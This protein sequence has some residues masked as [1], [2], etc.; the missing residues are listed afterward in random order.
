MKA[1]I[2]FVDDEPNVLRSF[3][4]TLGGKLDVSF[5][6]GGLKAV[7]HLKAH[8]DVGVVVTDM[9][10][11]GM[12]GLRFIAEA[13]KIVPQAVFVML[14]GN[15]DLE[16]ARRAVNEG[17]VFRFLNKPVE[18]DCLQQ[19]LAASLEHFR[20]R[21]AEREL[22]GKTLKGSIHLLTDMLG[23]AMPEVASRNSRVAELARRVAEMLNLP[24]V[25]QIEV[26]A[27]L[28]QIG[29]FALPPH[30][31]EADDPKS[32]TDPLERRQWQSHPQRALQMLE[33][34]PRLDLPGRIIAAQFE[35]VETPELTDP[36]DPK[37]LEGWSACIVRLALRFTALLAEGQSFTAAQ[38]QLASEFESVCP[39]VAQRFA[40]L[41]SEDVLAEAKKMQLDPQQLRAGMH[42]AG[43]LR[44]KTGALLLPT[45]T[46]INAALITKIRA[47]A[48]CEMLPGMIDVLV[49]ASVVAAMAGDRQA[50]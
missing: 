40:S 49:P 3:R 15:S 4:R 14:T 34:I 9:R 37:Q 30:L 46:P 32:I 13:R 18:S 19:C 7:E 35:A 23:L 42:L 17:Q 10:M 20:L 28:S 12:D 26:S 25:W 45:G 6:E 29:R 44:L 2:L 31:A 39:C 47:H 22:L 8:R 36:T 1:P 41:P 11:P 38:K 50:A 43:D 16:T 48:A 27:M 33:H 21:H 24:S 5:A